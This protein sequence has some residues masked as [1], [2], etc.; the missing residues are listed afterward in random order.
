MNI[1]ITWSAPASN[2]FATVTGYKITIKDSNGNFIE[3][4]NYCNGM[5]SDIFS[6]LYCLIPMTYLRSGSFNLPYNTLIQAKVSA[7][8]RNG[9]SLD[10]DPNLTGVSIQVEP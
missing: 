2:N 4:L 8:N 1:K 3:D 7:L 10:S 9:W 6:Q 5:N